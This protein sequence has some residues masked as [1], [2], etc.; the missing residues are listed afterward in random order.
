MTTLLVVILHDTD[1]LPN[2]LNAW[3]RIGVP[4]TTILPSFGGFQARNLVHR[5]GLASLLKLVN[6]EKSRQQTLISLIDDPETLDLAVSEADRVVKG[7]DSPNSGIL[8]TL[9]IGEV[10]GLQ[11]WSRGIE[12]QEASGDEQPDRS[13][14]NLLKW[15]EEDVRETHGEEVL[16]D[17]SEQRNTMVSEI[18]QQASVQPA[19]VSVDTPVD[20]ILA[21]LLINPKAPLI[22]VV[23]RE[24]RLMGVI[25]IASLAD[26]MMVSVIPEAYIDNPEGYDKAIKFANVKKEHLAGE[27]MIEPIYALEDD[28]LEVVYRRMKENRLTGLPLV[29]K[30]YHVKGF[31]TLVELMAFC[32]PEKQ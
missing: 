24:E 11:K 13:K 25:R 27:I 26:T 8:F 4:G 18:I 9:P 7:F 17:W 20:K 10:L 19:V 1:R 2:L 6:Q 12:E 3:K 15:F 14:S 32:Y 16:L 5:S 23:N 30:F 28:T 22:C 21:V 29:D 31:L